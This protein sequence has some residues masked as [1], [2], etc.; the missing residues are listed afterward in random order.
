MGQGCHVSLTRA[1]DAAGGT[2]GV[3]NIEKYT[4]RARGFVPT[5]AGAFVSSL[6]QQNKLIRRYP[7]S[8]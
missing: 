7:A 8:A 1:S 4:D 2:G 6:F 5:P 3:M